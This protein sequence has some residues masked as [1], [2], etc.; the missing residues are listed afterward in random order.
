MSRRSGAKSKAARPGGGGA[1]A[2][3]AAP[4]AS[5][6]RYRTKLDLSKIRHDLRRPI[7]QMLAACERLQEEDRFPQ[8][9][10]P[11]LAKIHGGGKQL[12][13][14]IGEYLDEETF[15]TKRSDVH[16]VC[17]DLRTPVNQI[18]GY[19]ELLQ[20]QASEQGDKKHIPDLQ[21]IREAAAAWLRLM[22]EH[23]LPANQAE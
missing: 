23:L 3:S 2:A 8:R 20:E 19:S 9:L 22:E 6:P 18:I 10:A 5:R 21:T 11:D 17:H 4:A 16:R 14:L 12:L 13:A 15:E 7:N 1:G